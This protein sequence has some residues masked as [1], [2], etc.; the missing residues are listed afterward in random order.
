MFTRTHVILLLHSQHHYFL[1]V[2][3]HDRLSAPWGQC[4]EREASP[5]PSKEEP[6]TST[7]E[8]FTEASSDPDEV[9]ADDI[10]FSYSYQT[11]LTECQQKQIIERCRCLS[12]QLPLP[13]V[14][15]ETDLSKPV[16]TG[17]G[18][19]SIPAFILH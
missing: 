6:S 2:V 15:T 1:Q 9:E 16:N 7:P 14:S 8:T 17:I 18:I 11:C 4:V 5:R 13:D 10:D 19:T 12:S 3:H